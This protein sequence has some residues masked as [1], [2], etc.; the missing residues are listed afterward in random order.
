M[1]IKS[2][3]ACLSWKKK[4]AYLSLPEVFIND[5][6]E[7]CIK[8]EGQWHAQITAFLLGFFKRIPDEHKTSINIIS[9][10]HENYF[11]SDSYKERNMLDSELQEKF[12]ELFQAHRNMGVGEIGLLETL[13]FSWLRQNSPLCNEKENFRK[14]NN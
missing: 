10:V 6:Q 13:D 9:K 5:C 2:K 14:K 1:P 12:N 8:I 11:M 4:Y 3:K 7:V